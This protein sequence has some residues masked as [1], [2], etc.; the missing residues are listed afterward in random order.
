MKALRLI[1]WKTEPQLVQVPTTTPG[2]GEVVVKIG[3]GVRS[4][5]T[6]DA[7]AVYGAWGCGTCS[8]CQQ[9]FE[10]TSSTGLQERHG[11]HPWCTKIP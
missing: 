7:F 5:T 9:G 10:N 1:D 3:V 2:P 4:V 6:G 11:L 8:R